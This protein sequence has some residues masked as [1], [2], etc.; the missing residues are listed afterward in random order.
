LLKTDEWLADSFLHRQMRKHFR[1]GKSEVT[2]QFIVRSD[3]YSTE[4][5]DGKLVITVK[6]AKKYGDS[7]VLTTTTSGKNVDLSG[8]NLRI[9]SKTDSPR[10][11]TPPRK[12]QVVNAAIRCWV[13]TR[14]TPKPSPT[15]MAITTA[16]T[17]A[18]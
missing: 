9:M 3:K 18:R 6:I 2:N 10:F 16:R 13:S 1:H 5:V 12:A 17:S 7:I 15:L 14:A 4:V 8:S 11:T